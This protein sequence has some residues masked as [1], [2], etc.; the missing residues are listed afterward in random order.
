[1]EDEHVPF[2][3]HVSSSVPCPTPQ[4]SW[5][6]REPPA[7]GSLKSGDPHP[8]CKS[9]MGMLSRLDVPG[10]LEQYKKYVSNRLYFMDSQYMPE[11]VVAACM[12]VIL[13]CKIRK[14]DYLCFLLDQMMLRLRSWPRVTQQ[15]RDVNPGPGGPAPDGCPPTPASS[16]LC[17]P[18]GQWVERPRVSG[19]RRWSD[20]FR[21]LGW[22]RRGEPQYNVALFSHFLI[23]KKVSPRVCRRN[24]SSLWQPFPVL[25]CRN[26]A[27]LAELVPLP[28]SRVGDDRREQETGTCDVALGC[29][30]SQQRLPLKVFIVL[31]GI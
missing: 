6:E 1:M 30:V 20:L 11:S 12:Y 23:V 8:F 26:A 15:S 2:K 4:H 25:G 21:I 13:T 14:G 31:G 5:G 27:F 22:L 9:F 10:K 18:A 16:L 17:W 19:P 29:A 7:G 3:S 24:V 28:E